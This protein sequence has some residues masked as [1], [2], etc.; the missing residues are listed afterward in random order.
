MERKL[1]CSV[2]RPQ[3]KQ[4]SLAVPKHRHIVENVQYSPSY[5]F[6]IFSLPDKIVVIIANTEYAGPKRLP[7]RRR[8]QCKEIAKKLIGIGFKV[9][10]MY[11]STR[12]LK[13]TN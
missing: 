1:R 8:G 2:A 12:C 4:E 6:F 5:V 7:A 3:I 11:I 13:I 9:K 10:Q